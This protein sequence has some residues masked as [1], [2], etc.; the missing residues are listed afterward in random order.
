MTFLNLWAFF[1][2]IPLYI[3]YKKDPNI[4]DENKTKQRK[5]LY[6]S[7]VFILLALA[8]PVI[9]DTT[10]E[11]KFNS[12][13]YIIAIDAS[14]SMQA[15]DLKPTRYDLAKK[16]IELL[17]KQLPKDRFSIF[18]F[19]SNTILISPPTLDTQVSMMALNILNPEFILTKGT[20]IFNLLTTISKISNK[21][22]NLIIFS[23]GGEEHD[24][25]KLIL[26]AKEN[27]IIP[28]VIATCSKN[29]AILRKNNF[30]LKDENNNLVISMINPILKDFTLQSGGKFYEL[31]FQ[32]SDVIFDVISDLKSIKKENEKISMQV[33]SFSELFFI[34]LFL[35]ILSFL[36]AITEIRQLYLI[37][38]PLIFLPNPSHASLF[39]R[40]HLQKALKHFEE[41]RYI[42]AVK[43]F[44]KITPSIQSYYNIGVSYYKAQ[45]YKEAVMIFAKIK[46]KDKKIKQNIFYNMGNCATKLKKYDRAKI[47]YEKALAF[48]YDKDSFTNLTLLYKLRPKQ[49]LDVSDMLRKRDSDQQ[50]Q[51][52]KKSNTQKD[53]NK[54]SN[55]KSNQKSA[56]SSNGSSSKA[57]KSGQQQIKKSNKTNK[58]EYKIGYKAYELI[59]KGYTNE[60]HPW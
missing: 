31:N 17:L 20:S 13:D 3:I 32:D 6:L 29:G 9:L 54:S 53:E 12:Q 33:L 40:G 8:R 18:A 60:K 38:L 28:F 2:L 50:T 14:Y 23:D 34:P 58:S 48:G 27:N 59:N 35:A 56:Q 25:S 5:L 51:A 24:L 45:H 41:K 26:M 7:I 15:N 43:E 55:S 57:K 1:I 47:Y 22:K 21:K 16:N 37:F 42:E 4:F 52:S 11:Q 30:N 36:L 49:K 46:T 44:E 10:S 19:T 39:D